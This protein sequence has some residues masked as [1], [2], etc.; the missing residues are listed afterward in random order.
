MKP[1]LFLA[2]GLVWLVPMTAAQTIPK[3][4]LGKWVVSR[5]L[6]TTTISCWGD[7]EAKT[8]LGT[9]IEYSTEVFRWKNVVT[10]HPVAKVRIVSAEKF[11]D[12]NS[13]QGSDS[14]QI[15]FRQ[16]GIKASQAVEI[17]IQHPPASITGATVE[18]PGDD[19]IVKDK[20]TIVFSVCNVYFE[21][22]RASTP[23]RPKS[24]PNR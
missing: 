11:H 19:V 14:S 10:N 3:E 21:A 13:G 6:P 4:I 18:I 17:S 12:D 7:A 1:L 8:L 23:P 16:L 2:A 22:T 24:E 15:T 5:E 20:D 9:E